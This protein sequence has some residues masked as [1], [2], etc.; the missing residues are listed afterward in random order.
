MTGVGRSGVV[1]ASGVA[2]LMKP[3]QQ[4]TAALTLLLLHAKSSVQRPPTQK[5]THPT[6]PFEPGCARTK[7][8][9]ALKSRTSCASGRPNILGSTSPML[10][11]SLSGRSEEHTSEL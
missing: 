5:P 6:L 1:A 8:A 2:R 9:A 7:S 3:P 4:S 10:L 11:G